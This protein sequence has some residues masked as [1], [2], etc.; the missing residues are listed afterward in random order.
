MFIYAASNSNQQFKNHCEK[1]H[2]KHLPNFC[3][4]LSGNGFSKSSKRKAETMNGDIAKNALET[5]G[6]GRL[7]KSLGAMSRPTLNLPKEVVEEACQALVKWFN[8]EDVATNMLR[9]EGFAAFCSIISESRY[10]LPSTTKF[11]R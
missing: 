8:E 7:L 3:N 9:S 2:K 4:I 6:A 11:T 10:T 5:G 1:Y